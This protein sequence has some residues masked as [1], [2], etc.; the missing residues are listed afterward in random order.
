MVTVVTVVAVVAVV[1]RQSNHATGTT[2]TRF[3][4]PTSRAGAPDTNTSGG[5]VLDTKL[6]TWALGIWSAIAFVVCVVYGLVTPQSLHMASF[7][8]QVLPAF[9]WLTWQGF[10]LGLAES[11]LYGV[12]AGLTFCP[13]YNLLHR[14]RAQRAR[15]GG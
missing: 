2:A 4:N 15:G 9:R 5:T 3:A 7:L 14:R 10:V 1:T 12:Y 11:F 13:V 8:E 6:V